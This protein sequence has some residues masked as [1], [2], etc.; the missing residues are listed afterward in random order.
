MNL[1]TQ[2]SAT[3]PPQA[4]QQ[5]NSLL[6]FG[7][8]QVSITDFLKEYSAS[9]YP[10]INYDDYCRVSKMKLN[11]VLIIL[12]NKTVTKIERIQ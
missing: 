9:N 12:I 6:Q 2:R 5:D 11:D 4:T 8:Y 10:A 7:S 1:Q 3:D